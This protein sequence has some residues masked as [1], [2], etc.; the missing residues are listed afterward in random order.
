MALLTTTVLRTAN[1]RTHRCQGQL[2]LVNYR[3]LR[4]RQ[5]SGNDLLCHI[6]SRPRRP[7]SPSTDGSN[8]SGYSHALSSPL[9]SLRWNRQHGYGRHAGRWY[10]RH[11]LDLPVCLWLV[12][13]SQ[14]C[15]L[16]CSCG[17]L[18]NANRKYPSH[19]LSSLTLAEISLTQCMLQRSACMG[20]CFFTNWI[21][22]YGI[23]RATPNM[24]TNMGY[25]AFLLYALLTYLGVVF[26]FFC[27]PELKGRS[28]ESM[29]DLFQRPLWTLWRHAYPTAEETVRH[30]VREAKREEQKQ[31]HN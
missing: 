4:C 12:L 13:R 28:I 15:L 17:D 30:G 23:T 19:F 31:S 14:R 22:D 7:S 18:P 21:I 8:H 24:L 6:S 11:N 29:D 20:F 26:I 10:R 3:C 27:L 16:H 25:G 5:S 2:L 1:I 9:P